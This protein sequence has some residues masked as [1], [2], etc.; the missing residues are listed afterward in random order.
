MREASID[1]QLDAFAWGHQQD[2]GEVMLSP[3]WEV[4]ILALSILSVLNM[5]LVALMRSADLV[6]VFFIMDGILT[7]AFLL[8]LGRRLMVARD[9]WAYLTRGRGWIDALA[10]FPLL[11]ILRLLRIV[12]MLRVLARLGGPLMAFKAF[13]SNRAAGGLLSV[14]FI[15]LLVLEFGSLAVLAVERGRAGSNLETALDAVWYTLVTMSTVGYG[16]FFPV[17]DVGRLIG[18]LIIIVGVG[19]FG[20][21]TGFLANFFLAPSEAAAAAAPAGAQ[22][23]VDEPGGAASPATDDEAA[24]TSD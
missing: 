12:R 2:N 24:A 20:T 14:L 7:L 8:D 21:L 18:S 17:T 4:F 16:D 19:V 10:A 5:V 11:R 15:A 22:A 1:Q 9:R 23:T 3:A 13:F 6:Q